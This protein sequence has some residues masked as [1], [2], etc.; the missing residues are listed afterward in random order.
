LTR[1]AVP[2]DNIGGKRG[3]P[4]LVV[5]KNWMATK[6]TKLHPSIEERIAAGKALRDRVSR[7][8]QGKWKPP[9]NRPDPVELLKRADETRLPELLPI[10]YGRMS[11]SPFGFFRGAAALMAFDLSNTPATGLRVQAC[12]DCHIGNFGG[13]GSPERRLVFDINDFDE[14]SPAPWEWD[15]KRL[16]ASVVLAGRQ[17]KFRERRCRDAARQAVKSYREHMRKYA[18]MRAIDAWY[19]HLEANLLVREARTSAEKKRWQEIEKKAKRQTASQL[20]PQITYVHDGNR[21]IVDR[22]PLVYHPRD[23]ANA[24]KHVTAMFHRYFHTLPED[25]RVLLQRYQLVDIARK[26]VGVGSVGTR[27]A[28]VLLLASDDDPLFLQFKEAFPSVLEPYTSKSKYRNH[29][30]RVVTGQR[31]LQSASDVFLGWTRDDEDR[32]YY[33]RQLRDMKMKIDISKMSQDDFDEYIGLCGWAL[34]RGHARTG[35]P[36]KIAGY[37]GKSDSFDDAIEKFAVEYADQTERDY[38]LLL[39]ATRAHG[40]SVRTDIAA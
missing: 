3:R 4:S 29:G 23:Y 15:V 27:C 25:R 34:A 26:V 28:V 22:P 36:A 24:G 16:A 18:H 13:F 8:S 2:A 21:R 35:D 5:A 19:S 7:K 1:A 11:Q 12:G 32:C 30:E 6:L 38:E 14:T 10:R 20:L 17:N 39:K 37:L 33:F 40:L 9:A 31:M